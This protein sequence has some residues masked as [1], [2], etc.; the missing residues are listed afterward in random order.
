MIKTWKKISRQKLLEHKRLTVYEDTV[1]L[2]SG[3][4]TDYIHFGRPTDGVTIIGVN[5]GGKI[6]VQKEYSYPPDEVL[7]QFPGGGMHAGENKLE[8]AVRE[9]SEEASL[10]GDLV[11][12]GSYLTD[13]RRRQDYMHVFVATNLTEM[14]GVADE[15]EAFETFW[16]DKAEIDRLVVEGQIKNHTMLAAWCIYKAALTASRI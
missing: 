16:F 15:E 6:L 1:E 4:H 3:T 13:N 12:I 14:P 10:S 7:Y 11:R 2:P 9:F 5:T 8:A